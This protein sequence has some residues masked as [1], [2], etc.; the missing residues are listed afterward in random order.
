ML[1]VIIFENNNIMG[2]ERNHPTYVHFE[3]IVVLKLLKTSCHNKIYHPKH[4][5]CK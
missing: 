5:D 3:D 1:Q 2:G 4:F